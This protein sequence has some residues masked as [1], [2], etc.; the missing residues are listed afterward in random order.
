MG[1]PLGSSCRP[2]RV[3]CFGSSY[4]S[5]RDVTKDLELWYPKGSSFELIGYLDANFVGSKV[6]S[7]EL[8]GYLD[9][10]FAGS[11][12]DRKSTSGTCQFLGN[13][14]I[15]WFSKKQTSIALPT[16]EAEYIAAASCCA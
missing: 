3:S 8:I 14:L 16:G 9:V 4:R 10:D 2:I 13:L 1:D 7:F 12:V 15:S 6:D 11:K 5:I